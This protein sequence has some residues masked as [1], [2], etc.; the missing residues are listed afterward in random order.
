MTTAARPLR[1]DAKVIGLVCTAHLMSHFYSLVVPPIFFLLTEEFGVGYAAMGLATS[2][3]YVASGLLQTPAGF[4]VDRLGGRAVLAGGLGFV[5]AGT[6]LIGFAPSYPLLL[7]AFM[8]AGAGNSVFHPADMAILNARIDPPR[9]G[10]AFSLHAVSGNLGWVVA[11]L[12]SVALATAF[13]WRTAMIAAGAIGLALTLLLAFQPAL[14][15]H[16]SSSR[17]RE[18]PKLR[19][20]LRLLLSVPVLTCFAFFVFS[21]VTTVGLQTFS[22]PAM[23]GLYGVTV[24]AAT[25]TLTGYLVGAVAG[26]LVGGVVAS[27]T[28]RHDAAAI[29]GILVAMVSVLVLASGTLPPALLVVSM[30]L[31]GFC[32]GTVNPSRDIVVRDV[33]PAHAR[34]KVYGFVYSGIDLGSSIGPPVVGW[35][36]DAGHPQL[37]FVASAGALFLGAATMFLLGRA[38][39]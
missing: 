23:V 27:R 11:P 20:D 13:G 35:L 21:S 33:T 3:F 22:I 7:V 37:V 15:V 16:A 14:G 17:G 12:F 29:A 26:T 9:L 6:L 10:Y 32:V 19:D 1:T 30:T 36:L 28:R 2:M 25:G 34:G 5:S 38:R 24:T 8:I 31:A 18:K 39:Q 4:L